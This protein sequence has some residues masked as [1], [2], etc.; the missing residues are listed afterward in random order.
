MSASREAWLAVI[1][2]GD[3][4]EETE[5]VTVEGGTL[6]PGATIE[7]TNGVRVTITAPAEAA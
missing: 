3:E 6:E 7:I 4:P 1:Q 2:D 5:V